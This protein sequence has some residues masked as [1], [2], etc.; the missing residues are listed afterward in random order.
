[1]VLVLT[2]ELGAAKTAIKG[3]LLIEGTTGFF[4]FFFISFFESEVVVLGLLCLVGCFAVVE[5]LAE[6][7]LL[8]L[9]VF[10]GVSVFE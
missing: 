9:A 8:V 6:L 5:V 3:I 4:G 1:V 7:A 2:A 10:E